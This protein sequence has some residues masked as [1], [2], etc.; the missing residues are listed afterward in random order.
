MVKF[1]GFAP[2]KGSRACP[3]INMKVY[4]EVVKKVVRKKRKKVS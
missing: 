1:P 3:G 2:E 4:R